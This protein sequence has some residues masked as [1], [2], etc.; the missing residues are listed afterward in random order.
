MFY[1]LLNAY[2]RQ[3]AFP[4]RGL[5]YFLKAAKW[6][7]LDTKTYRK[8]LA[9][10]FF[11]QLNPSEHIQ[12]Q[13]FWY[14]YYEKEL[15]VLIKNALQP[16]D[17]FI[18]IGANIGYFS[19]LAAR[20]QPTARIISIEPVKEL[21]EKLKENILLNDFKNIFPV[22][23]AAGEANEEKELFLSGSDNLGMSSFKQPENYS[24]KKEKVQVIKLD[25]WFK[26][27]GL[28]KIDLVKLDIEGSELA[29]LKGMQEI[30][31]QYKPQI[32]I[33]I[34]PGTL[35][36]F[37]LKP[38]ALFNF[39][40]DLNFTGF[41]ISGSCQLLPVSEELPGHTVNVV[42]VPKGKKLT[43]PLTIIN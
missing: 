13:L 33:E 28:T 5:K 20:Q 11:M 4:H 14:G 32:I 41:M 40:S 10:N 6:L 8:K 36:L 23:A 29:A 9:G 2:T 7:N 42:F 30:L 22:N 43:L 27:S 17:V 12:R 37:D 38:A 24:G 3:F 34:N 21:F 25:D 39:L 31:L 18:D 15:G 35:S 26:T 16:G 1:R 19:L